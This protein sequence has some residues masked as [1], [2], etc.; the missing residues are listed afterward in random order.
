MR[1]KAGAY[2]K[3]YSKKH[4]DGRAYIAATLTA[5]M[6]LPKVTL[7]KTLY[8]LY[9]ANGGMYALCSPGYTG[10]SCKSYNNPN[11]E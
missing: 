6:T 11:R 7:T 2:V 8:L 4:D 10:S 1:G 5:E 9:R 3:A